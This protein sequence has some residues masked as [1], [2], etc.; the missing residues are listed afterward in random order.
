MTKM[1]LIKQAFYE[2]N[3]FFNRNV[4]SGTYSFY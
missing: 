2:H 3:V 4:P 1:V